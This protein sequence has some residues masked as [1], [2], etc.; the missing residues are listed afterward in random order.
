MTS[1]PVLTSAPAQALAEVHRYLSGELGPRQGAQP[2]NGAGLARARTLF[3]LLG[4]PQDA[5]RTVHVAGT[6]GKGSV[7]AFTAGL[8]GA[9]GFRV[10]AHTSPHVYSLLER[11]QIDGQPVDA[12][13][14]LDELW[15]IRPAVEAMSTG[16]HGRPSFFEVTN[17]LAFAV[18]ADRVDYSVIE[19][20]MGGLLDS[21]NTI[22]RTDKFAVLTSIGLDHVEVLGSTLA[23]IAAQKAG[24][25]P[26]G[27]QGVAAHHPADGIDAA[28]R[29][30]QIRRR[31]SVEFVDVRRTC[32][33]AASTADGTRLRL[34][35][36]PEM[37]LGLV[38]RHQAGNA[39]LALRTVAAIAVRDGWDLDPEAIR[40]GLRSARLPGRFERRVV[41]GHPVV[42]D[43]AHNPIKLAALV[44]TLHEIHPGARFPWVLAFK[45]D[46]DL[47]AAL[48]VIGPAASSVVATEFRTDGGDHPAGHSIPA[49][50]IAAAVADLGIPAVVEPHP[51]TAVRSAAETA[52]ASVPV[53]VSGSFHLLAAVH[54]A[55]VPQ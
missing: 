30:E 18:F 22:S 52:E 3:A 5:V 2:A 7:V 19:T 9:H 38:G 34:P 26:F 43:G 35:G 39:H 28:I 44:A 1:G 12:G 14:L 51:W 21:T 42:L 15:R 29:A 4:D 33:T 50:H 8:L 10:G 13:I 46:K 36:R 11:F 17:A 27:G 48:R 49:G 25:L 55:T 16:E 41:A 20:G 47:D 24:I 40:E 45:Q 23:E 6:A 54:G 53:V 32:R 37:T 31:C